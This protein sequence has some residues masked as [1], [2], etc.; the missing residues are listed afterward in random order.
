ML[1]MKS[2]TLTPGDLYEVPVKIGDKTIG[3]ATIS[4]GEITA[5]V[6]DEDGIFKSAFN[7]DGLS[8]F[9]LEVM[10]RNEKI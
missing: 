3:K 7:M 1:T 5:L 9:S 2:K 6:N 8:G 4:N 10:V